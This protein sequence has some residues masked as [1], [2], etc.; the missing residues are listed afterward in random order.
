MIGRPLQDH[1]LVRTVFLMLNFVRRARDS[2]E[3]HTP[4]H[5]GLDKDIVDALY[6][7]LRAI[8]RFIGVLKAR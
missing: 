5:E 4:G 7:I 8:K 2:G 3:T 6:D 1:E